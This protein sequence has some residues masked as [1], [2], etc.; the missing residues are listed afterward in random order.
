MTRVWFAADAWLPQGWARNV[1]IDVAA[2]GRIERME[3]GAS[4]DGCGR[5]DG[6]VIPGLCDLHS[7][8]FQRAM[9]GLAERTD[10]DHPADTFWTW[11][12]LMYRFAARLTPET[13]EYVTAQLYVEL[14]KGGY[15][16]VCE[17]HYMHHD[18]N[19]LP[20]QNPAEMSERV[21][22]AARDVGIG[23]TLLPVLYMTSNF[24]GVPPHAGQRRFLN[25]PD[26]LLRLVGELR[27]VYHDEICVGVAPH[28]LR[29]VPPQALDALLSGFAD[30]GGG[31]IHMHAAEQIKEVDDCLAWCGQR[32]VQWLLDHQPVN[33]AWCI[34]H[35]THMTDDET[36]GLARTGGVAG[37][38]PTTEANLGDGV[39]AL[40]E[41]VAQGGV[42]G[43]GSD[44]NIATDCAEELRWLEYNQRLKRRQRTV[45]APPDGGSVGAVLYREALVGGARASGRP[46]GGL[47][48][49]QRADLL[50]LDA[51]HPSL[52]GRWRDAWLDAYIFCAHGS[53]IR[54]VMV[55]GQWVIRDR[56]HARE[57][58]IAQRYAHALQQLTE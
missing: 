9:A 46:I 29:A 14:L 31:P 36:R 35:A 47:A 38:C 5:V 30:I 10:R 34:V 6:P 32:P 22:A 2:D 16:T 43:I 48:V 45:I 58:R 53:P 50:V 54:D 21:I 13:L 49:G 51:N 11:R 18:R 23:L 3:A 26:A 27:H 52:L 28:S 41:Y 44:S 7:H 15:T 4:S 19:G 1:R 24:G 25:D 37:L 55:G 17:F 20:Y 33:A 56:R 42:F 12:E 57:E 8:S 40:P 39:F